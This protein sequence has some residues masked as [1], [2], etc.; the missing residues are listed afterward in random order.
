MNSVKSYKILVWNVRGI[1]SQQKWNAIKD[2]LGESSA[3]IV[4]LQETKHDNFDPAYLRNFCPRSLYHFEFYLSVG[5]LGGLI[6]IWNPA[7]F[8][9]I[10]VS[11]N[12][13]SITMTF[14]CALTGKCFHLTNIYGPCPSNEKASFISWLYNFDTSP[15]KNWILAGDFNLMRS[16][17]NRNRAGGNINDMMLFNDIIQH[18]D[19]AEI[20]FHLEQHAT[21]SIAGEIGLGVHLL[22]LGIVLSRYNC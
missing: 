22:L 7:L 14:T 10:L 13:Y 3:G 21:Y 9:G 11:A 6:V 4:C 12:A 16:T 15:F 17:E 18:L 19:L 2:K 1:N 20:N 5:A 8:D